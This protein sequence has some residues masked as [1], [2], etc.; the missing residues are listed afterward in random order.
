MV[1]PH[2]G[3]SPLRT[4]L[5]KYDMLGPAS[6]RLPEARFHDGAIGARW[7]KI[8]RLIC[9]IGTAMISG[10]GDQDSVGAVDH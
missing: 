2:I 1:F 3:G 5:S 4:G 8:K 9:R 6:Y 10:P 7:R